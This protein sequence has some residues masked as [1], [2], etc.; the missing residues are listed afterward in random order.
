MVHQESV[1]RALLCLQ[2]AHLHAEQSREKKL[3]ETSAPFGIGSQEIATAELIQVSASVSVVGSE[4]LT[5]AENVLQYLDF[6]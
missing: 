4:R 1:I 6:Y 2:L 3:L 5:S